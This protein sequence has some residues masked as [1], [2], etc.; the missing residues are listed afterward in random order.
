[1]GFFDNIGATRQLEAVKLATEIYNAF[2]RG[3]YA[4]SLNRKYNGGYTRG[5]VSLA[6]FDKTHNNWKA[7]FLFNNAS[8][9]RSFVN[10][11]DI[12][13]SGINRDCLPSFYMNYM[14]NNSRKPKMCNIYLIAYF[15]CELD[16]EIM[17]WDVYGNEH[18]YSLGSRFSSSKMK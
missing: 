15:L 9:I 10:E 12:W 17:W 4:E 2:K 3:R 5:H 16:T 1:M 8:E 18:G 6:F 11:S 14:M 7:I 13:V